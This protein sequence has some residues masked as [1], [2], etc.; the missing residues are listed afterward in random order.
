MI[1]FPDRGEV[2]TEI[3]SSETIHESELASALFGMASLL[4]TFKQSPLYQDLERK[5]GSAHSLKMSRLRVIQDDREIDITQDHAPDSHSD[6]ED[7]D[8]G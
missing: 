2:Y 6:L 4:D 1:C 5:Y 7:P 8:N 3:I